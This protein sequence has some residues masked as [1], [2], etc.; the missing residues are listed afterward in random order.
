MKAPK[1][2]ACSVAIL[3]KIEKFMQSDLETDEPSKALGAFWDKRMGKYC[4]ESGSDLKLNWVAHVKANAESGASPSTGKSISME[5]ID[6]LIYLDK[7]SIACLWLKVSP[8]DS[9]ILSLGCVRRMVDLLFEIHGTRFGEENG[10]A[11]RVTNFLSILG[12]DLAT[13]SVF[14][15][16]FDLKFP[17]WYS[18]WV[19]RDR[20]GSLLRQTI[21][22][23]MLVDV[24]DC[25]VISYSALNG[26][27][28]P[29]VFRLWYSEPDSEL[30]DKWIV[31]ML[32]FLTG[33][34]S[35]WI[36]HW[37]EFELF[38]NT[39]NNSVDDTL[40]YFEMER[41]S[42]Y[43]SAERLE[44]L[45]LAPSETE[46]TFQLWHFAL[47]HKRT[48]FVPV[49]L[50]ETVVEDCAI[51]S[52]AADFKNICSSVYQAYFPTGRQA[53][54]WI[55]KMTLEKTVSATSPILRIDFVENF[56]SND[57]IDA[58]WR[59]IYDKKINAASVPKLKRLLNSIHLAYSSPISDANWITKQW[60]DDLISMSPSRPV[61]DQNAFY[62]I[63]PLWFA[64]VWI[65]FKQSHN[66]TSHSKQMESVWKNHKNA[67]IYAKPVITQLLTDMWNAYIPQ[68]KI[69][70]P[71]QPWWI[72]RCIKR[73]ETVAKSGITQQDF[74]TLFPSSS[75][76]N[77]IEACVGKHITFSTLSQLIFN[78]A[79]REGD[80]S[81]SK[82]REYE[83]AVEE[84]FLI[85]NSDLTN[86]ISQD[87]FT[88]AFPLWCAAHYAK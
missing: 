60:L 5:F 33:K 64:T 20:S 24:S 2:N 39:Q 83:N 54:L 40:A 32:S 45:A 15:A 80:S 27:L 25:G 61:I 66:N 8:M 11:A 82:T 77:I 47:N 55:E 71:C 41:S 56:L 22:A 6:I 30:A 65:S 70:L 78:A 18:Y 76:M 19:W 88:Y 75:E 58:L 3:K 13:G 59:K 81:C 14:R 73:L 51:F 4:D 1:K 87:T 7:E 49:S 9:R 79:N 67:I 46:K 69:N 63:F 84:F 28:L 31:S 12:G 35:Q 48:A 72:E 44:Y 38:F 86:S 53:I 26:T 17:I 34:K 52:N 68:T 37:S 57:E 10:H 29:Y 21:D 36:N 74:E 85:A 42:V 50:A 43:Y 23:W 62:S 16:N